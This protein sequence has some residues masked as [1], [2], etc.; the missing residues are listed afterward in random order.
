M[1]SRP[2]LQTMLETLLGSRN[3]YNQPPATLKLRYPCI[4]YN[5][6]DI[7]TKFA[8]NYPYKFDKK[9]SLTYISTEPDDPFIDKLAS[10][11]KCEFDRSF[12]S[13]NL[14]HFIFTIYY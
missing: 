2:N 6:T 3:V 12:V 7:I 1:E 4:I 10:L 11:P 14:H 9:Y 13:D 5:L 8:D